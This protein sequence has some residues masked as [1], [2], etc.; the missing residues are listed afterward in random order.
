MTTAPPRRELKLRGALWSLAE[1][2]A[3]RSMPP[4]SL[5]VGSAGCGKT[6]GIL[7]VL[8]KL[9]IENPNLRILIS[10]KERT[11]LT[12]SALVTYEQ[13]VLPLTGHQSIARNVIRRVRQSY[14]YPNG[15]EWIVGGLDRPEKILSTSYDI[16]FT[17]EAIELEEADLE[18]L[19][20][21]IGRPDR[22]GGFDFWIGDTNPGP[23]G[24]WL[25]KRCDDGLCNLWNARHRDNPALYR[26]GE[27]TEAGLRYIGRLKAT[28]T[29]NRRLRL[30]DGLWA[31]G[32]GAWFG[33][34][35]RELHV[36][37]SAEYDPSL[38]VHL[39]VDNGVYTGGAW[40]QIRHPNDAARCELT[41]FGD[42]LSQE[43]TAHANALAIVSKGRELCGGRID[44]GSTDPAGTAKNAI[45]PTVVGEYKR[46]GLNLIGW[47]KP[48]VADGLALIE[49]FVTPETGLPQMKIHPRCERLIDA[50]GGYMRAKRGNQWMDYPADPLH[51]HEDV[52]DALRGGLNNAF[53]EG[54]SKPVAAARIRNPMRNYRG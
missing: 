21:R 34:F 7:A 27:W 42:Y 2:V 35:D 54:R 33:K 20:S 53:P 41:I 43:L 31:T 18:T 29:G 4:E 36:S 14:R 15:T 24:H 13:E 49:S 50:F 25:K 37:D 45:G 16:V 28:L 22:P 23:P 40:F 38:P 39:A 17:N 12:E 51:P 10:R 44:R 3:A 46:A 11:T 52:M 32:E 47:P 5:M 19:Q 9:S 6:F 30:L 26:G 48:P 8:H 1:A